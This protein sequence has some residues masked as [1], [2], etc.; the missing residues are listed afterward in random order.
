MKDHTI[1]VNGFSKTYSMTGWRLG[2][3]AG[4]PRLIDGI[5][6]I[7]QYFLSCV[8]SFAQ[9]GA[10]AALNHSQ[11]HVDEMVKEFRRRRNLVVERIN[12]IQEIDLVTPSGSF[13]AFP[14]FAR[15]G[16]PSV[17][18]ARRLLLEAHV[19]LVP[20]HAYGPSGEGHL[21]LAFT[22]PVEELEEGLSR[23]ARACRN[24]EREMSAKSTGSLRNRD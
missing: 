19:A 5:M 18:L 20:G 3:V 8:N 7:Q 9:K 22:R 21:R 1:L 15:L 24:L 10:I 13:Y 2:Y 6:K 17:D 23:L 11:A 4:P 16:L 12:A 14:S